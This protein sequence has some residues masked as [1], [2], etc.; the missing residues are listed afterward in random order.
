MQTI[1][2][3][4]RLTSPLIFHNLDDLAFFE[5]HRLYRL[6]RAKLIDPLVHVLAVGLA[7][8]ILNIDVHVTDVH[9]ASVAHDRGCFLLRKTGKAE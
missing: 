3:R 9:H 8:S 2:G 5:N 6:T 7:A 4:Q 1:L